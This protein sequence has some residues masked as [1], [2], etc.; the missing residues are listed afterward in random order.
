MIPLEG[1]LPNETK[2]KFL[3]TP[4]LAKIRRIIPKQYLILQSG[5]IGRNTLS[6][7]LKLNKGEAVGCITL[8]YFTPYPLSHGSEFKFLY[9]ETRYTVLNIA[10][11][12]N[13]GQFFVENLLLYIISI[14]LQLVGVATLYVD[15]PAL[16]EITFFEELGFIRDY[17]SDIMDMEPEDYWSNEPPLM[18]DGE[19]IHIKVKTNTLMAAFR[20]QQTTSG[21]GRSPYNWYAN[22][23][24]LLRL[25]RK[26]VKKSFE[27]LPD[28]RFLHH[29]DPFT[30]GSE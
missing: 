29:P 18:T 30:Q 13:Y 1:V 11:D 19:H 22:N 21:A 24:L 14:K 3:P 10:I 16:S 26:K 28:S 25:L 4:E 2:F 27:K 8:R 9:P 5:S 17:H 7:V 20:D 12:A 15:H 23:P 6:Y